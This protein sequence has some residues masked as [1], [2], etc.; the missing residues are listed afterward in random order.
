MSA[1][2]TLAG[3][4]GVNLNL[5]SAE[6]IKNVPKKRN[7]DKKNISGEYLQASV[8]SPPNLKDYIFGDYSF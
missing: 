5:L 1:N 4:Y 6:H 3:K 8:I 7:R 2:Y